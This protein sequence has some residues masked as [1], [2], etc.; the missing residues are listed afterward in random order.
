MKF[1]LLVFVLSV[2]VNAHNGQDFERTITTAACNAGSTS[3]QLTAND[4]VDNQ[5]R[6][7]NITKV[8]VD[9]NGGVVRAIFS[10]QAAN[11]QNVDVRPVSAQAEVSFAQVAE[12][13]DANHNNIPDSGELTNAESIHPTG[14]ISFNHLFYQDSTYIPSST[15]L[16]SNANLTITCYIVQNDTFYVPP[17]LFQLSGYGAGCHVAVTKT[18]PIAPG[19][20]I[21]L[22]LDVDTSLSGGSVDPG[23][24]NSFTWSILTGYQGRRVQVGGSWVIFGSKALLP[25]QLSSTLIANPGA[26]TAGTGTSYSVPIGIVTNSDTFEFD[27]AFEPQQIYYESAATS[28]AVSFFALSTILF[29]AFAF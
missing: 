27:M 4:K 5:P 9:T 29:V 19:N 1:S 28:M 6:Q 13:N 17:D 16:N 2:L 22:I 26:F 15:I 3:C 7:S 14:T 8:I 20:Q 12:W 10:Y 24:L 11:R 23:S 18:Q 21:A 25:G